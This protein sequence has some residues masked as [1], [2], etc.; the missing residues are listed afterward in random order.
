MIKEK[1]TR[2]LVDAKGKKTDVFL[3]METN[4]SVLE[5]IDDYYCRKEYDRVK[6]ATDA[7]IAQGDFVTLDHLKTKFRK[8]HKKS[9]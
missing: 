4:N 9:A 7:E 1:N 3:D 5:I 2:Y 6:E 8:Q